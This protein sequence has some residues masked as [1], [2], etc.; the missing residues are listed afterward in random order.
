MSLQSSDAFSTDSSFHEELEGPVEVGTQV[1]RG[2]LLTS[3]P[4]ET[5]LPRRTAF[6]QVPTAR[7]GNRQDRINQL[8]N[9][10]ALLLTY[11]ELVLNGSQPIP[12]ATQD[13]MSDQLRALINEHN[14][15]TEEQGN[16]VI[17]IGR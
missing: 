14:V 3:Q 2:D 4:N 15:L 8:E 11:Q 9:E 7:A 12:Q 13:A 16:E 10:I 6:Q 17:D 1:E 5:E